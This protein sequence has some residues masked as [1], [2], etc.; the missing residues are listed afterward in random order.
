M[1]QCP[2]HK[3]LLSNGYNRM[4]H[5]LKIG[6]IQHKQF[7]CIICTFA[8]YFVRKKTISF[9]NLVRKNNKRIDETVKKYI[10]LAQSPNKTY[11]YERRPVDGCPH[12]IL[13]FVHIDDTRTDQ[14]TMH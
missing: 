11:R 3:R 7:R 14:R 2:D 5:V 6:H 13:D 10:K 8:F 9:F 4:D 12:G 1:H